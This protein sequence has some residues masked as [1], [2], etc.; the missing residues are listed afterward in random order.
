M[1]VIAIIAVVAAVSAVFAA[2]A[3]WVAPFRP[4][5]SRTR[6][7]ALA[8]G[9]PFEGF[10]VLH[11]SDFHLRRETNP[12]LIE[13][14]T[15]LAEDVARDCDIDL[16]CVTGDLIET[17]T[18][19]PLLEELMKIL[20]RI[21]AK[22]GTVAVLGNHD[23]N[24]YPFGNLFLE[25]Y[26][27]NQK[28]DTSRLVSTLER[29]N[30]KVLRNQW[31]IVER[32][33]GRLVVIGIDDFISGRHCLQ[34]CFE[35]VQPTDAVIFLTHS[36]DVVSYLLDRKVDLV[37]A[38]HTHGGQMCLPVVGSFVSRSRVF[39]RL[40]SGLFR[41][42]DMFVFITRGLGIVRYAPFRFR[43]AP[44]FAI[45]ELCS[46]PEAKPGEAA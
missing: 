43:C 45:L 14:I 41:I 16:I 33:D 13:G 2:Y 25:K 34:F 12:K 23:Y 28:N 26:I 4:T 36:P 46:K 21:G 42:G 22:N 17:D 32:G 35:T 38:G 19:L 20:H 3:Y 1:M 15:S 44:E 8:P 9:S 11:L 31:H 10:K 24:H 6:V 18:G 5:V 29:A 40:A 30:V 39:K 7:E 27:V 37:L